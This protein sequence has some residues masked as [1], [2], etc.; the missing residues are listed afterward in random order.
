MAGCGNDGCVW[1]SGVLGSPEGKAP[2]AWGP[3][4]EL[5]LSPLLHYWPAP[6]GPAL[7][8]SHQHDWPGNTSWI[9]HFGKSLR[10]I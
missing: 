1:R 2:P 5:W 8:A 6:G 7:Q 4:L 3:G 10:A 9:I